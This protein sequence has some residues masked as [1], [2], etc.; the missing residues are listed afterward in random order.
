M[1]SCTY[2]YLLDGEVRQQAVQTFF[3]GALRFDQAPKVVVDGGKARQDG[4]LV[5]HELAWF[6]GLKKDVDINLALFVRQACVAFEAH[7]ATHD[8]LI[9]RKVPR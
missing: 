5:R 6:L 1:P 2:V 8:L 9:R 7:A 3:L 4:R